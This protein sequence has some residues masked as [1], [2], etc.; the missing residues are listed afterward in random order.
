MS[1]QSISYDS[2]QLRALDLLTERFE[3][4][5]E[6][7]FWVFEEIKHKGM[8]LYGPTGCGKTSVVKKFF[9]GIRTNSR[10]IFIHYSELIISI[11]KHGNEKYLSAFDVICFDEFEI[12]D[13]SDSHLVNQFLLHA[14]RQGVFIVMTSNIDPKIIGQNTVWQDIAH[15]IRNTLSV[16]EIHKMDSTVDYRRIGTKHHQQCIFFNNQRKEYEALALQYK[17]DSTPIVLNSF[18]RDMVFM[19]NKQ[20]LLN[21]DELIE[22]DFYYADY[23]VICSYFNVIIIDQIKQIPSEN[24]NKLR[25]LISLVDSIYFHDVV[26][27]CTI[28]GSIDSIS[29]KPEFARA[30]SR[31]HELT[32]GRV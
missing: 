26:L 21:G 13:P 24:T 32:W 6:K 19:A 25:R 17:T 15:N 31:L 16:Y 22:G 7:I 12:T 4:R 11:R 23:N 1:Q 18:G 28:E 9:N 29:T 27:I 5:Y 10:A 30:A 20:V 8:Y 14:I 2:E 3:N